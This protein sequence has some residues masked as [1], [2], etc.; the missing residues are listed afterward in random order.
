MTR[1]LDIGGR[2]PENCM[3][4]E[5][6]YPAAPGPRVRKSLSLLNRVVTLRRHVTGPL[7]GRAVAPQGH[8]VS[9]GPWGQ[10]AHAERPFKPIG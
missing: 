3:L 1:R 7:V 4:F 2:G 10:S 5:T 6:E 8:G 9:S